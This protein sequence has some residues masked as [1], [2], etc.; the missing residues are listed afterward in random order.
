MKKRRNSPPNDLSSLGSLLPAVYST[1]QWKNQWL[2]FRLV[3]DWPTIVGAEI[4][5]LTAPAFFRQDVLWIFVQDSAWMHHMQFIKLDL[6][7][8]VNQSLTEK[9]ITDIR[10]LLQPETPRV[11]ERRQS[12]PHPVYPE[13]ERAFRGMAEGVANQECREALQRLWRMFASHSE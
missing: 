1:K 8:R 3:R 13:Q 12:E 7:V 6:L 5:R 11:P 9:P 4:A 10:W 2:L